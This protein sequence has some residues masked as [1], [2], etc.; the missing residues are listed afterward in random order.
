ML[1]AAEQGVETLTELSQQDLVDNASLVQANR[2][3]L[4]ARFQSAAILL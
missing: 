3:G 1:H 2:T 4:S